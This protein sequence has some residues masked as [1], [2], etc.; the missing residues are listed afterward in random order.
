MGAYLRLAPEAKAFEKTQ[1][2]D[3]VGG[4]KFIWDDMVVCEEVEERVVF[5]V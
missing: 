2:V 3:M 5:E 1:P 4:T